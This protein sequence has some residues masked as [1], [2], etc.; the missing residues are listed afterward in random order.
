[1]DIQGTAEEE[2]ATV[3]IQATVAH[4]QATVDIQAKVVEQATVADEE[5]YAARGRRDTRVHRPVALLPLLNA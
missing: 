3:H 4:V 5:V 1:M 2:S